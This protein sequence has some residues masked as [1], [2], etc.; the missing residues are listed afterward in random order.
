MHIVFQWI[1]KEP[2]SGQAEMVLT[3]HIHPSSAVRVDAFV[4]RSNKTL[5]GLKEVWTSAKEHC[6]FTAFFWNLLLLSCLSDV[7]WPKWGRHMCGQ[8]TASLVSSRPLQCGLLGSNSGSQ[9]WHQAPSTTEP[10]HWST[11]SVFIK[12]SS[13]WTQNVWVLVLK[14]TSTFKDLVWMFDVKK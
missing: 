14:W 13:T 3:I 4:L 7:Y 6:Y 5:S 9:A 10:S 1:T 2:H 12:L 11:N 8:E